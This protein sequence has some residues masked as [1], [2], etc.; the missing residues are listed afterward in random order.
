MRATRY[1]AD[2]PHAV[3]CGGAA[4]SRPT[5]A[6]TATRGLDKPAV[7][8]VNYDYTHKKGKQQ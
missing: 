2:H 7:R 3:R 8:G 1:P 4:A 6:D 5:P